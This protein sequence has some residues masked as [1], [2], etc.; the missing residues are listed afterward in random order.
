MCKKFN[1]IY[2]F[3]SSLAREAIR[4]LVLDNQIAPHNDDYHSKMCN[5]VKTANFVAPVA[6]KKDEKTKA[7]AEKKTQQ[8]K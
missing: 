6:E 3:Y 7:P 5:Y 1:L 2:F 8:K 4:N